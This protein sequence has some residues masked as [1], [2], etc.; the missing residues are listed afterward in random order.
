MSRRE[1]KRALSHKMID[2][3]NSIE[4]ASLRRAVSKGLYVSGGAIS[5]VM[6]GEKINDYDVYLSGKATARRLI[7]YYAK[8]AGYERVTMENLVISSKVTSVEIVAL[9]SIEIR[10]KPIITI[11]TDDSKDYQLKTITANAISL[12]GKI[13]IITKF[14]GKPAE[15]HKYFDFVHAMCYFNFDKNFL[16][17]PPLAMESMLSKKLIY[18]GSKYPLASVFRL[19]KFLGRGW[20]IS[21]GQIV[22]IVMNLQ[23]F[24]LLQAAVFKDQLAGVDYMYMAELW[25]ALSY[26][27]NVDF[28]YVSEMIDKLFN[29]MGS[30]SLN[31]DPAFR[32]T[33]RKN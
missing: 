15:V 19:R 27:E 10:H 8:T 6:M 3:L 33:L 29:E 21:A 13:Q 11:D 22:K 23:Q 2:W 9:N 18:N 31:K 24:D 30:E 4:D 7:E 25:Q 5:S 14:T 20:E 12:T 16:E 32:P 28:A 17:M 26:N 1:V